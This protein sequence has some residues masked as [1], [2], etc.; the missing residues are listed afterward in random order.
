MPCSLAVHS[1]E[2]IAPGFLRAR[3]SRRNEED[4]CS[5]GSASQSTTRG[6]YHQVW[7]TIPKAARILGDNREPIDVS[8]THE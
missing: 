4:R 2:G 8:D 1:E 7:G 5:V 3:W 6:L